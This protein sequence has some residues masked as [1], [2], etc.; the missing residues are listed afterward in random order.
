MGQCRAK[1][2]RFSRSL[3]DQ[4]GTRGRPSVRRATRHRQSPKG[5]RK[6]KSTEL[7]AVVDFRPEMTTARLVIDGHA[8]RRAPSEPSATLC[9]QMC[10]PPS[11]GNSCAAL[12]HFGGAPRGA[13]FELAVQS[14]ISAFEPCRRDIAAQTKSDGNVA[15]LGGSSQNLGAR[16][17]WRLGSLVSSP[18]RRR[19]CRQ[20]WA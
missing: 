11:A 9:V 1:T 12:D 5:P 19:P 10:Q 16:G 6:T 4:A 14:S 13:R 7:G 18:R 17:D 2:A 3:S 20:W 15:V 8:P